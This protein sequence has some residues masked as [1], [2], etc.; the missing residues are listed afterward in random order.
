[1]MERYTIE[2]DF[3]QFCL[4]RI[5]SNHEEFQEKRRSYYKLRDQLEEL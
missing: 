5:E 3:G 4:A 2:Q 1:M